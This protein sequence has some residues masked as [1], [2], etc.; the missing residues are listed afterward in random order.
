MYKQSNDN[1]ISSFV[2]MF[3]SSVL[4]NNQNDAQKL[5][6][7]IGQFNATSQRSPSNEPPVKQADCNKIDAN[8]AKFNKVS[9][10]SLTCIGRQF[11]EDFGIKNQKD[12]KG[13]ENLQNCLKNAV[14]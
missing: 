6:T 14:S 13:K 3:E 10:D 2:P 7:T 9:S 1:D 5:E 8:V 12:L 4:N 11:I